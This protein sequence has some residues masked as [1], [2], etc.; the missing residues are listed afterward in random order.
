MSDIGGRIL[1]K[2]ADMKLVYDQILNRS[3][4]IHMIAPVKIIDNHSCPVLMVLIR[5]FAPYALSGDCFC[6]RIQKWL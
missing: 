3:D 2:S 5:L 6:I 1:G 4:R